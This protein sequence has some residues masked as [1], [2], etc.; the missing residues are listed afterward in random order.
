M[1]RR[2]S[3]GLFD[4]SSSDEEDVK[5]RK[6]LFDESVDEPVELKKSNKS[7]LQQLQEQVCEMKMVQNS[8]VDELED[9]KKSNR[10]AFKFFER[11]LRH[12]SKF[13]YRK[14][15]NDVE[16]ENACSTP[17]AYET[18]SPS[19]VHG[20]S[21]LC[22]KQQFAPSEKGT[23]PPP[24]MHQVISSP[25]RMSKGRLP[26]HVEVNAG[27]PSMENDTGI[28]RME[29]HPGSPKMKNDI[30]SIK[31]END[32][33]TPPP[34]QVS[35]KNGQWV[36]SPKQWSDDGGKRKGWDTLREMN[37]VG[38]PKIWRADS[39]ERVQRDNMDVEEEVAYSTPPLPDESSNDMSDEDVVI[40]EKIKARK[41]ST[42]FD[43]MNDYLKSRSAKRRHKMENVAK[44]KKEAARKERAYQEE[45]EALAK[46][47]KERKA[48][49]HKHRQK[50]RSGSGKN[51]RLSMRRQMQKERGDKKDD[52]KVDVVH[53][54][55]SESEEDESD[56]VS[57]ILICPYLS[58]LYMIGMYIATRAE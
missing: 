13:V 33:G 37:K 30:G 29:N 51:I 47:E 36:D 8:I 42:Q 28:S 39:P 35:P 27:T 31:T 24:M 58:L 12:L 48:N 40:E 26:L 21:P 49:L 11:E 34:L 22:T 17:P 50:R 18:M 7:M 54:A 56:E 4:S 2:R 45:W 46:A 20:L 25:S 38:S 1:E 15:R 5:D 53:E 52:K 44:K 3:I 14:H 41:P 43:V 6:G 16:R 10:K 32:A 55:I 57:M 9:M 19:A 23:P